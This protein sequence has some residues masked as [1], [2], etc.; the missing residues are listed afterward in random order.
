[1]ILDNLMI[2]RWYHHEIITTC[3]TTHV[4]HDTCHHDLITCDHITLYYTVLPVVRTCKWWSCVTLRVM[5]HKTSG[6]RVD[7]ITMVDH[8]FH[9]HDIQ[10]LSILVICG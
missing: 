7:T 2:S 5:I 1:M 10:K 3:V 4:T 9:G 6:L 8:G